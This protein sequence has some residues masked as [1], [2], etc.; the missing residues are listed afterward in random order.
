MSLP[1]SSSCSMSSRCLLQL[2]NV[3]CCLLLLLNVSRCLLH[4]WMSLPVSCSCLMSP[5]VS[6]IWL[7]PMAHH[8]LQYA[9]TCMQ[10]TCVTLYNIIMYTCILGH[11]KLILCLSDMNIIKR[12]PGGREKKDKNENLIS[13]DS[14]GRSCTVDY[15]AQQL[16]ACALSIYGV[17][18]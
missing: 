2:L 13:I 9:R 11:T 17:C 4:Y 1:V 10:Y 12:D 16:C 18:Y 8:M 5:I 15:V 6:F 14:L 7:K 3:S